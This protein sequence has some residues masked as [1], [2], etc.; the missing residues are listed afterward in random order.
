MK[1]FFE[2]AYLLQRRICDTEIWQWIAGFSA[3]ASHKKRRLLTEALFELIP[4]KPVNRSDLVNLWKLWDNSK[5]RWAVLAAYAKRPRQRQ[6][7]RLR[8]GK[9]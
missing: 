4:E 3:L 8:L 9:S 6:K 2:V 7:D 5:T 1:V